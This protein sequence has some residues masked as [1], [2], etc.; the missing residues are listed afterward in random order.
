MKSTSGVLFQLQLHRASYFLVTHLTNYNFAK[1]ASSFATHNFNFDATE[2]ATGA[3]TKAAVNYDVHI[4]V[5]TLQVY[6]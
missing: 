4:H 1:E 6:C 3:I 5:L 2:E